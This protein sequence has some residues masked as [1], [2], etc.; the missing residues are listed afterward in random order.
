MVHNVFPSASKLRLLANVSTL[1]V[2]WTALISLTSDN[3]FQD[4]FVGLAHLHS[5][6]TNLVYIQCLTLHSSVGLIDGAG[7]SFV[8][9]SVEYHQQLVYT[10]DTIDS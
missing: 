3:L 4:G 10:L 5:V 2:N 1:S 9:R 8:L 7:I 6:F